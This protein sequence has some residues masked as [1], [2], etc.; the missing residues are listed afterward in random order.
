MKITTRIL[1]TLLT[2]GM[3]IGAGA[4]E[5]DFH[6]E[7]TDTITI[8]K[9]LT[10]EA[11]TKNPGKV[12]RIAEKFI[13]TPYAAGTLE[14]NS[15]ETLRVNLDSLDCTTF[16]ETVLALAYTAAEQRQSWHD[17]VYNLRRLRYRNG[18]TDGY[19][20]RLHY[21]SDWIVDNTARG[22]IREVTADGPNVRYS[23]KSLDFMTRHREN[24]PALADSA[25]YAAMKNL[26]SG[27]SNHRY[28]YIKGTGLKSKQLASVARDGDVV[29]F[30]TSTR[31]LDATHM[32]I[33]KIV[34]GIPMMIHASSK[35]G[36]VLL[37]PLPIADYVSRHRPEGIRLVRLKVE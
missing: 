3:A 34:D 2:A 27:F 18:E 30:T 20:S 25:N 11:A 17:F 37:D 13:N 5:V 22:N 10:E 24:Y 31:G 8:T 32:G 4:Q 9:L 19:A 16:V 15:T 23:V 29:I 12:T 33:V 6:N 26:E 1:F 7:K 36:K 28:P 14:G 21:V 35:A